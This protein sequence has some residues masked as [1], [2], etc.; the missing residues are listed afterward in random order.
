MIDSNVQFA[1]SLDYFDER[2]RQWEPIDR[3]SIIKISMY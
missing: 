2:V 1:W 3:L